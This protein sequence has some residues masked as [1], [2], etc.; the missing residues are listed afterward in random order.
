ERMEL[1]GAPLADELF[2]AY[3]KQVLV[4]GLFHA[5]PHP[6]NVFLMEDK[7]IAL[8]DL[9][10][11]G[12]TTPEMQEK[13]IKVLIA[14]SE[15]KGEEAV[16]LVTAMSETTPHFNEPD[17]RRSIAAMVAEQQDNT[18]DKIDV[19]KILLEVGRC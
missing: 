11:V 19:G 4:D 18:L 12:R 15:G 6:G 10:M 17:F 14:I 1:E 3:L 7:R 13:L 9:G 5:D 16:E 2:K 8:L